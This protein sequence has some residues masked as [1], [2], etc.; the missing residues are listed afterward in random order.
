MPVIQTRVF[1][2]VVEAGNIESAIE[3]VTGEVNVFLATFAD[4]SE[5]LDIV[6]H[7]G[8]ASKY[9]E[10]LAYVVTIVYME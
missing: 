5:V 7:N 3:A 4:P 10:R 1:K 6:Y 8:S 9:G 2:R